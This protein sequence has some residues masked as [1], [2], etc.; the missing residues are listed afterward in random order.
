[1][2]KII[3]AMAAVLGLVVNTGCSD[4]LESDSSRQL[5]DP[6]MDSKTDSVFYAFGIMQAMQ[7]LA[8]QYVFQG[9]MRGDNVATTKYTDNNLRKLANFSATTTDEYDSAYVYY[10]VINNC[11]YYIAHRDT[12][13]LTGSTN[14][15]MKEYAAVKAFRAWAYLQLVRNYGKVPFFTEPLTK[16]SQINNNNYPEL[17]IAGIVS[18]LAPDL[19]QYTGYTVPTFG[20]GTFD[21]GSTNWG[22]SKNA[23]ASLCCIPVDVILGDLYLENGDYTKAASHFTT[24]LTTIAKPTGWLI[25]P[26]QMENGLENIPSDFNTYLISTPSWANIFANNSTTD[27]I[28]YIPMAVNRLKGTTTKV[29]D[30]FGYKY[31]STVSGTTNLYNDEIQ[32]EPSD[33]YLNVTDTA[34][35]YYYT[36]VQTGAVPN[37]VASSAQLGDMRAKSIL[38]RGENEDS[39]KVWVTKYINGNII[40]YRNTTV[41]LHLAEAFNRMGH[42]DLAFAILKEGIN[43]NILTEATTYLSNQSK[44]L[45]QTTYPFLSDAYKSKFVSAS[46]AGVH[47]HGAGVTG[48]G[49]F[50]GRSPYKYSTIVGNK[51]AQIAETYKVS[52]GTTKQDSVNAV[53]DLLCDEYQLEFAFE[54]TRWYDLM[55]LARHKNTA[56]TYSSNFGGVWLAKKLDYKSPSKD[57]SKPEN[58]YLPFK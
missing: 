22:Q 35:F 7:Q 19:E 49:V 48:D 11:N 27:I 12:T 40:L 24:Y 51:L 41:M 23:T 45:I 29:P 38:R 39:T 6:S 1:M 37:S 58:W 42:P 44:T 8:D 2:K 10:R 25:A 47:A 13:L 3:I 15:V 9:E 21:L 16:I 17:D 18:S 30:A 34:S 31:Y 52:V 54:G 28:S 14:V 50:P 55:R 56:S 20:G 43:E 32:I 26:F 33:T 36:D 4:M 57:V 53:E 46:Y 5:F